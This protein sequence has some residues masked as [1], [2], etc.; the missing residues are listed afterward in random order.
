V[1]I[2]GSGANRTVGRVLWGGLDDLIQEKS[3]EG[4]VMIEVHPE[5]YTDGSDSDTILNRRDM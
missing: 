1:R 4:Y 3:E 5:G 2:L